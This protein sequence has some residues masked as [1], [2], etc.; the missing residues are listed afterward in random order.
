[1]VG[2]IAHVWTMR[3]PRLYRLSI[4][5]DKDRALE[6]LRDEGGPE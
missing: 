2:H 6:A 3:G 4:F 5:G 1:M